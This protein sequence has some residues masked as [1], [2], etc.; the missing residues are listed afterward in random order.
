[1]KKQAFW[2]KSVLVAT[3][4]ISSSSDGQISGRFVRPSF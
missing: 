1:M 3:F 4:Q 2:L